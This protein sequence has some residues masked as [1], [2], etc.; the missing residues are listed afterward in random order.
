MRYQGQ[1][2]QTLSEEPGT[3]TAWIRYRVEKVSCV[4]ERV[5]KAHLSSSRM[6][7]AVMGRHP[8]FLTPSLPYVCFS[9]CELAGGG[10]AMPRR[11]HRWCALCSDWRVSA[12]GC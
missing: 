1:K 9:A 6:V 11:A 12:T 2:G 7:F 8:E 4:F 3:G 10:Q 5:P